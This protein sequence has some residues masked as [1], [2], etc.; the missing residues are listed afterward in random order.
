MEKRI[1]LGRKLQ[2]IWG[3]RLAPYQIQWSKRWNYE[4]WM[5]IG[6]ENAKIWITDEQ[7]WL[8]IMGLKYQGGVRKT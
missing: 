4:G 7:A 3:N 5:M 1:A 2:R 6:E 8:F